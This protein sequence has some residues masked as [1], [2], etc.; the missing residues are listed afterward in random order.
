M[1]TKTLVLQPYLKTE[2]K[3]PL[4]NVTDVLDEACALTEAINLDI[5]SRETVCIS[6]ISSATY[7]SKGH[8]EKIRNLVVAQDVELVFLNQDVSPVQQRNLEKFLKVK[9]IDRTALILE[10]FGSRAQTSE[11]KL[12]VEL[13]SLTYQKSRLVK[14]WS[15]LERQ[16]GGFGFTGGPGESQLVLD[17]RIIGDRIVKLKNELVN[18]KRTRSL[19][20]NARKKI[21]FPIVSLV[22]YTNAGK[23]TLF[24]LLT[25]ASVLAQ[26]MLFATLDPTLRLLKLPS[27]RQV[28][29]TDTVGFISKLPH[30]LIAAFQATLEEVLEATLVL[31]IRDVSHAHTDFQN[32][33]V[34]KVLKDVGCDEE[35]PMIEVLNKCDL[36]PLE[37]KEIIKNQ[38]GRKENSI[39][40]SAIKGEGVSELLVLIDNFLDKE[41]TQ[42][43]YNISHSQTEA[44]AWL[45]RNANV[46][47]QVVE[48][49]HTTVT[50]FMTLEKSMQFEKKFNLQ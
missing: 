2:T 34:H 45:F 39:L 17:K 38:T 19:Q 26:D 8:L 48:D 6:K 4:F 7:I 1:T 21:P 12:Q 46:K 24:N 42:F 44:I 25:N 31:H 27:G 18:V 11:G 14:S 9:V 40:V 16:K 28:I 37:Q 10:I 20:R 41:A 23:S 30:Q 22:G 47:K 50:V 43:I 49:E 35:K 5:V 32:T 33:Q 29:I 13:A 3:D 15:H 36:L